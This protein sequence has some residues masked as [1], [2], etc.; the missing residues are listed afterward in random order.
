MEITLFAAQFKASFALW[1]VRLGTTG[2]C[3]QR[4]ETVKYGAADAHNC[5]N[6]LKLKSQLV[7][8]SHNAA[9][10]PTAEGSLHFVCATA[11]ATPAPH[12]GSEARP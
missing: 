1:Q 9:T 11:V 5:E 8:L 4:Y 2:N 7:L 12:T 3:S 10:T 6:P